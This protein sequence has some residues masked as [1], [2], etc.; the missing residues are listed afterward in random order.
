M[1]GRTAQWGLH[2]YWDADPVQISTTIEAWKQFG[3][4]PTVWGPGAITELL[5][6]GWGAATASLFTRIRI[7]SCRSDIARIALL[8]KVGGLYADAHVGPPAAE[9]PLARFV[10][11][12]QQR[13]VVL[14]RRPGQR[15]VRIFVFGFLLARSG[16]SVLE[17]LIEHQFDELAAHFASEA[18]GSEH[19][20]YNIHRMVG[21]RRAAAVLLQGPG[22]SPAGEL[23]PEFADRVLL[24][25][26]ETEGHSRVCTLYQFYGYRRPG[27]HWSERQRTERL[28]QETTGP[29]D[30]ATGTEVPP[31]K[32]R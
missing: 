7:P 1:G 12:L 19:V 32:S 8:H 29:R 25:D 30:Q 3:V 23:R 16:S 13:E 4:E 31:H 5:R 27:D 28:F 14:P 20:P 15:G 26:V 9:E 22:D 18:L 11:L 17:T 21:P 6:E 2:F 24:P 10:D